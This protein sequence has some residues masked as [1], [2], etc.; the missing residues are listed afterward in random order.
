[1]A[2]MMPER[3]RQL[4]ELRGRKKVFVGL[5]GFYQNL[6][7]LAITRAQIAF[8]RAALPSYVVV[9]VASTATYR[10]SRSLSRAVEPDDVVTLIGGGNMGDLYE[11]L[12]DARLHLVRLFSANPVVSFPQSWSFTETPQGMRALARSARTYAR[13]PDLVLFARESAS[14]AAMEAAFPDV[15]VRLAPDIVLSQRIAPNAEEREGVL[16]CLRD[17]QEG[18]LSDAARTRLMAELTGQG[19]PI[20]ILDTVGVPLEDC[21]ADRYE[22]TLDAFLAQVASHRMVVTDRLHCMIFCVVTGTPCVALPNTTG[23]IAGT[24]RDWLS[25]APLV[26]FV[27][28][29]GPGQVLDAIW[30]L[31]SSREGNRAAPDLSAQFGPLREALISAAHG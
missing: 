17:D 26:E 25:E 19:E 23:K 18:V 5:A 12:E 14:L 29:P 22:A 3:D 4:E 7:D 6:G 24:Y 16:V 31:A 27:S 2:R 13:H 20:T 9:P 10:S 11:S 30:K 15:R 28:D 1:M 21:T 8:V